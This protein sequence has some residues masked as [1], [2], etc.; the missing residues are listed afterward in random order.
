MYYHIKGLVL[1]AGVQAEAD[2]IITLYSYEWGKIYATVP[3][4]KKITAKL[5]GATEP[6]TESEFMVFQAHPSVRPKITGA[7]IIENNTKIK[8]DFKRNLYALYAAEISAKLAPYNMENTQKYQLISRIWEVLGECEVPKRALSAFVLRLLK[9]SGY[10]FTDY[11]K[12]NT[13]SFDISLEKDIRKLS[14]CSGNS[15]DDFSG[16]DDDKIWNYLE[17][18]LS[19]YIYRPSVGAF[20]KKIGL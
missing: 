14:R 7:V 20:I 9:L 16:C 10:S 5:A 11:L 1:N 6:L 19:N 13:H 17:S 18:Y 3:G 12:N 8:T 4:A 15:L 2:K